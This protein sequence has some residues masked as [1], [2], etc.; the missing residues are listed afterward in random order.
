MWRVST[1]YVNSGFQ[2]DKHVRRIETDTM[3]Y[4]LTVADRSVVM[5]GGNGWF[6]WIVV[7]K[8]Q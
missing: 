7:S 2:S 6:Q 8:T 4:R 5:A 3:I 1:T